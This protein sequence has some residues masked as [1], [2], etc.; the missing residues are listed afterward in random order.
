MVGADDSPIVEGSPLDDK[1]FWLESARDENEARV[2]IRDIL[3]LLD[4]HSAQHFF[5]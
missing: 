2:L 5:R 1:L 4:G 3:H